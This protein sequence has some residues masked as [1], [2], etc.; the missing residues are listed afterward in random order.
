MLVLK[1]ELRAGAGAAGKS[2]MT[3]VHQCACGRLDRSKSSGLGKSL[4]QCLT[5]FQI[6]HLGFATFQEPTAA[7][8][9]CPDPDFSILS[10]ANT[11]LPHQAACQGRCW[12]HQGRVPACKHLPCTT[13]PSSLASGRKTSDP[14][15]RLSTCLRPLLAKV[16]SQTW[17]Q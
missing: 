15:P 7:G 16:P 11:D 12:Q 5:L 9:A 6:A 2:F 17:L 13:S 1:T 3:R 8:S 4:Q 10:N 14:S